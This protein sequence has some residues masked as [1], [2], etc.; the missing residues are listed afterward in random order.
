MQDS[1]GERRCRAQPKPFL[2]RGEGVEKRVFASKYRKPTDF[3]SD[4]S[5]GASSPNDTSGLGG[6][7]SDQRAAAG[8]RNNGRAGQPNSAFFAAGEEDHSEAELQ[9]DTTMLGTV[10]RG[11]GEPGAHVTNGLMH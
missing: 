5:G 8:R 4:H 7:S 11:G 3:G 2:K 9:A 1:S 6:G 10:Y